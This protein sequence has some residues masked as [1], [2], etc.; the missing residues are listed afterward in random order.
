MTDKEL[1]EL[2]KRNPDVWIEGTG[3]IAQEKDGVRL[4]FYPIGSERDLQAAIIEE[5]DRRAV[6]Q[7]EYGLIFAI[8]NGQYR[9]GQ[10]M[11]PGLRAGVP[12]L[13]LPVARGRWHGLFLELK[14]KD[15]KPS[16]KQLQW[17]RALKEQGYRVVT[18]W[19]SVGAAMA[20]IE[21]YLGRAL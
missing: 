13:L 6:T 9:H 12:D 18:I 7:P 3:I 21:S 19:D 2:L 11:E 20:E 16:E 4:D 10:R 15:N 14:Y 17:I 5:C 8:P 1:A